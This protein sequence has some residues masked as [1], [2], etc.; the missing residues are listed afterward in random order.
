MQSISERVGISLPQAPL[1]IFTPLTIGNCCH[2]SGVTAVV[3]GL[4]ILDFCGGDGVIIGPQACHRP[5]PIETSRSTGPS[6]IYTFCKR[7][8][9]GPQ[10]SSSC[11]CLHIL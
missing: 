11:L 7:Q 10:S 6:V 9:A 3:V 5:G 2:R 1:P 8:C 4:F